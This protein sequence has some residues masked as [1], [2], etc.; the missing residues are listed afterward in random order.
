MA[1]AALRG[2]RGRETD[3]SLAVALRF[4]EGCR[5]ADALNWLRLGL[6]AHGRMPA[7]YTLPADIEYRTVPEI[8]TSMLA[9]DAATGGSVFWV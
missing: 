6:T 1:L 9:D 7:G 5:S 2:T 4:L 3:E 8:A